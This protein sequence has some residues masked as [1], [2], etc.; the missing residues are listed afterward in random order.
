MMKTVPRK[1]PLHLAY[2][3][4]ALIEAN[5]GLIMVGKTVLILAQITQ[6]SC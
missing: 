6:L 1:I 4:R 3:L 2:H 5:G